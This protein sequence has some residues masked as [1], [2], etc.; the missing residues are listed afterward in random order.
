MYNA[1]NILLKHSNRQL[2]KK[3]IEIEVQ[4]FYSF[5]G[6]A[7]SGRLTRELYLGLML[8]NYNYLR[9]INELCKLRLAKS[10]DDNLMLTLEFEIRAEKNQDKMAELLNNIGLEFERTGEWIVKDSD[11]E[12]IKFE[13]DNY[14]EALSVVNYGLYFK[15]V[16][17]AK[18]WINQ[19]KRKKS[20]K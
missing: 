6:S 3:E 7:K 12:S 11:I 5:I 17:A 1:T 4:P 8:A 10:D 20:K 14:K 13:A 2:A 19:A 15:A 9:L 16:T 18:N